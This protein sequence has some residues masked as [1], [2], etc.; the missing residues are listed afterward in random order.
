MITAKALVACGV[1]VAVLLTDR[2]IERSATEWTGTAFHIRCPKPRWKHPVGFFRSAFGLM[3]ALWQSAK[4]LRAYRPDAVLA[5]GSYTSVGPVVA[6]RL[7]RIPVVL[8]DANVVPG[9]AVSAL[10]RFARTVAVSFEKTREYIPR[11]V[12]VVMTGLPIRAHIA[13]A[14]PL[15]ESNV[16]QAPSPVTETALTT[17]EGVCATKT[18]LLVMGG[19][20]GARTINERI[21]EVFRRMGKEERGTWRVIH[22]CGH[23]E[24]P[25]M[26][27]AY[28]AL[29]AD[30][31]LEAHL[32]GFLSEIGKAYASA[33]ICISRAGASSCFELA[34]CELP[35]I[36]IP[37][38][39]AARDHQTANAQAFAAAGA[40]LCLHQA[41]ATADRLAD[42][43]KTL[44]H[45]TPRRTAMKAALRTLAQPDAA[46]K[47]AD[48]VIKVAQVF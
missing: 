23:A 47:L 1:E 27:E 31:A 16:A 4:I 36:L 14:S 29:C 20:Q 34:L 12:P 48:V 40:A 5:M 8:H 35:S 25:A 19:S 33:D 7:C 22:L 46:N 10:S 30:G 18:T 26:R 28:A 17:G 2:G 21:L 15:L 24:E 39:T 43:L 37:L 9:S 42:L 3:G 38:P 11:G 32:Y 13:G 6:A 41:D 44:Q 45:D